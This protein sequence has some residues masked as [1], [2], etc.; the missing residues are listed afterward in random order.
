MNKLKNKWINKYEKSIAKYQVKF[1]TL[2][3]M[4]FGKEPFFTGVKAC[5]S[6]VVFYTFSENTLTI[7]GEILFSHQFFNPTIHAL[8][9]ICQITGF[10]RTGSQI[11]SLYEKK[12]VWKNSTLPVGIYMFK[13]NKRNFRTRC[14]ICSK[15][16]IKKVFLLLT[17]SR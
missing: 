5:L 2:S 9:T 1:G 3:F 12:S 15:L 13:F 7:C 10:M 8:L 6:F 14:E 11:P 17:L 4:F 16:T